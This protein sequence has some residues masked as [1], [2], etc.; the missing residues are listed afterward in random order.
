M[1]THTRSLDECVPSAAITPVRTPQ[2]SSQALE[3]TP[4]AHDGRV[5]H[6]PQPELQQPGRAPPAAPREVGSNQRTPARIH[7]GGGSEA[8]TTPDQQTARET[9][10]APH[11][12]HMLKGER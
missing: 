7:A 1:H 2:G 8:N 4:K 12:P 6:L 10:R 5:R 9:R 11:E 3:V